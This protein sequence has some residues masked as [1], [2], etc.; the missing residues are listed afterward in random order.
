MHR[1]LGVVVAVTVVTATV[2]ATAGLAA[3]SSTTT[4]KALPTGP[5]NLTMS[6]WGEQEAAGAKC[7]LARHGR[8][9]REEAPEREDQDRPADDGRAHPRVQGRSGR[10]E[11]PG[12]P[13]LLGWHLGA[14][15]CLA[16]QHQAGVRLHPE[17]RARALPQR[18]RGH[19]RREG[20]DG[21]VVRAAVV[22]RAVP[23][24]RAREGGR[25]GADDVERAAEGV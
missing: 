3:R 24:G 19:L 12:H 14:R 21:A 11:G 16:R 8:A 22:P 20:L 9:L 23:Q 17:V 1:K 4:R 10:Q 6:W 18:E 2:L 15:R 25:H 5:V 13:V 7:W